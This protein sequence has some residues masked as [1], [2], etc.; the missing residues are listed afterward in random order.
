M[1]VIR[2][3]D[4]MFMKHY[5]PNRCL[6]IKMAKL[7]TVVGSAAMYKNAVKIFEEHCNYLI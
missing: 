7:R 2:E 6:Y 4:L 3:L 1:T 5:V